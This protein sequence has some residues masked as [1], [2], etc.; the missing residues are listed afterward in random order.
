M[1]GSYDKFLERHKILPMDYIPLM[2]TFTFSTVWLPPGIRTYKYQTHFYYK[3]PAGYIQMKYD[4]FF[5]YGLTPAVSV[6]LKNKMLPMSTQHRRFAVGC[7]RAPF[8][9]TFGEEVKEPFDITRASFTHLQITECVDSKRATTR[10]A[11]LV[12]LVVS[13]NLRPDG[14]R[15]TWM[16]PF[17]SSATITEV[18]TGVTRTFG[19]GQVW[20]ME[21]VKP[22]AVYRGCVLLVAANQNLLRLDGELEMEFVALPT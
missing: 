3:C 20:T 2:N 22:G 5:Y 8:R 18:D 16:L 9:S 11:T 1:Y 7:H 14:P 15:R 21:Y 17:G 10:L 6:S 19:A 4:T 13:P 12:Q